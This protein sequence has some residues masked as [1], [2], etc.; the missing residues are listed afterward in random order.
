LDDFWLIIKFVIAAIIMA[1]IVIVLYGYLSDLGMSSGYAER[2]K[3]PQSTIFA[4]P[5]KPSW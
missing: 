3:E 5:R 2:A 4:P 1:A